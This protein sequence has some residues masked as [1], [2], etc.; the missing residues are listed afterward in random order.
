[1][2]KIKYSVIVPIYNS[3]RYLDKCINSI[4]NQTLNN[5]ELLLINDGSTDKSGT[6]CDEFAKKDK[7]IS[8]YHQK[9]QGV[10][11]AR[12][13]GIENSKGEYIV[14]IDSDDWVDKEFLQS[15]D[16]GEYD[17]VVSGLKKKRNESLEVMFQSDESI[18]TLSCEEKVIDFLNNWFV[19]TVIS[20][21]F[22]RNI[23]ITN[24]C[25]FRENMNYGE[26]TLFV[27]S[28][29]YNIKTIKICN[30]SLYYYD[31]TNEMSL[32][33]VS[34]DIKFSKLN[35]LM[36]ESYK[37]YEDKELV[38]NYIL[39]KYWWN[40]ENSVVKIENYDISILNKADK[41][42]KVLNYPFSKKCLNNKCTNH[43]PL[44]RKVV[45]KLNIKFLLL[46]LILLDSKRNSKEKL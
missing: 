45:Y 4:L 13:V 6:I 12:N 21:R 18:L 40:L 46:F 32:S 28:Y 25:F 30:S 2:T 26:D 11:K 34:D 41:V 5:F 15:L 10:S 23:I 27:T 3:E 31:G 16:C 35:N 7:R 38:S 17:L 9:N 43:I 8:V 14:F 19:L 42:Q 33:K 37:I 44:Y 36:E 1:M 39:N 29:I 22:V 24:N 20:K